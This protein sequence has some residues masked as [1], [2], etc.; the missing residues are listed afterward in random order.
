MVSSSWPEIKDCLKLVMLGQGHD[1]CF[2]MQI[3]P[4]WT[5]GTGGQEPL[6]MKLLPYKSFMNVGKL[7]WCPLTSICLPRRVSTLDVAVCCTQAFMAT[8]NGPH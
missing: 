2:G 8:S 3:M 7:D 1:V 5:M 4:A 6:R